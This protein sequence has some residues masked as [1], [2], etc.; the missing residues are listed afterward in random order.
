M[1]EKKNKK[2]KEK[3]TRIQSNPVS[4]V[5]IQFMYTRH[6]PIGGSLAY[7]IQINLVYKKFT[8]WRIQDLLPIHSSDSG[9]W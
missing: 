9:S 1:K 6:N 7:R 4:C 5:D 2:K 8:W 3:K